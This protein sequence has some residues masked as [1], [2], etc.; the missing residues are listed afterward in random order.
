MEFL[1][2]L[3]EML[4]QFGLGPLVGVLA[5]VIETLLR[6]VKTEQPKS[7]LYLIADGVKLVGSI[8]VKAGEILDKVLPQRLK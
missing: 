3:L 8:F 1:Q 2:K 4:T 7:I 5:I 6:L